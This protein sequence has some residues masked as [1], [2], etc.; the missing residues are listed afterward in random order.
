MTNHSCFIRVSSVATCLLTIVQ[1]AAARET[2]EGFT[3]PYR[4]IHVAS[5]EVGLLQSLLVKVGDRVAAGQLLASLDD[6][7]QRAQL[8]IARQQLEAT[9]RLKIAEAERA[10]NQRRHEKL[11]QLVGRG[12]ASVEEAERAKATLDISEGKLLAEQDE[13][14]LLELQMERAR[15]A[16]QKR[17][18]V[19]PTTGV[20]AEIHHQIG[21]FVSPAMPQ[22]VTIIELDPLAAAFLVNRAQLLKLKTQQQFRV[23]FVE[24]NQQAM[25]VIDSIAPLTDAESGTTAVRIRIANPTG[26]FRGGERCLL[27]LP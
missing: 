19:A 7:V 25:G 14:K 3:E 27:E 21:E 22:V 24:A 1:L 23:Q 20:V 6:D 26:Q 5:S 4:T 10:M 15:L 9:G 13:R 18:L 8:A 16:V 12:Q 2:V 11:A 17:S